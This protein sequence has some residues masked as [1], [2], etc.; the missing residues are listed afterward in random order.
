M[1]GK[2]NTVIIVV[3]VIV[4]LFIIITLKGAM[5]FMSMDIQTSG[6]NTSNIIFDA[7]SMYSDVNTKTTLTIEELKGKIGEPEKTETWDYD[8]NS[9]L[10]YSITTLT[11][12]D[13]EYEYHFYDNHLVRVSI[14]KDIELSKNTYLNLSKF[15]LK[16]NNA[17]QAKG[18]N[19]T[20]RFYDCGVND[21][22][23]QNIENNIAGQVQISYS[24]VL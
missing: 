11:Y 15:N 10:K 20:L 12:E 17:T 1:D 23:I 21:L 5:T 2:V 7:M 6:S 13:G 22:W 3:I 9:K 16:S 14:Y 24:D 18:N 8:V 19:F 4:V